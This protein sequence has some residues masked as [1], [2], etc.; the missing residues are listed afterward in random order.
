MF[1]YKAARYVAAWVAIVL[2]LGIIDYAHLQAGASHSRV[3][4]TGHVPTAGATSRTPSTTTRRATSPLVTST[5]PPAKARHATISPDHA[6]PSTAP[7]TGSV[8]P[9]VDNR[10]HR[11]VA[12]ANRTPV[13][14]P[15]PAPA[16]HPAPVARAHP[17]TV[18]PRPVA[19]AS[20][21]PVAVTYVVEPN[22][23]LWAL[24][25]AH[26]GSP[27]LWPELFALNRG[28]PQPGGQALVNP[29]LIRAGWTLEFPPGAKA[30][31]AAPAHVAAP[32]TRGS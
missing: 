23:T 13:T 6:K 29:D 3:A 20:P 15:V 5:K 27:L 7:A 21:T 30:S 32:N 8:A 16:T 31:V 1:K 22:D 11:A 24:A 4:S 19:A 18:T 9:S 25:A 12:P 26:L 28:R 17:A 2:A 14:Q 10:P